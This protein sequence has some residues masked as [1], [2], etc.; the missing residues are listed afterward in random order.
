M[1]RETNSSTA[2]WR[3]DISVLHPTPGTDWGVNEEMKA[4]GIDRCHITFSQKGAC[5]YVCDYNTF[6]KLYEVTTRQSIMQRWLHRCETKSSKRHTEGRV[7]AWGLCRWS[8]EGAT[9]HT[10]LS[11]ILKFGFAD[12]F[13]SLLSTYLLSQLLLVHNNKQRTCSGVCFRNKPANLNFM[14]SYC[15]HANFITAV[16]C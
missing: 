16:R 3:F 5:D 2:G 15:C 6:L 13:V 10:S 7:C 12:R 14:L 4:K 9:P 1:Q 8:A 11:Y